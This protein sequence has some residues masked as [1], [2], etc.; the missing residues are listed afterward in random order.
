MVTGFYR[1]LL[2]AASGGRHFMLA[3][4]ASIASSSLSQWTRGKA[5][6]LISFLTLLYYVLTLL[7]VWKKALVFQQQSE[8]REGQ[9]PTQTFL[10]GSSRVPAPRTRSHVSFHAFFL[11][12]FRLSCRARAGDLRHM[13]PMDSFLVGYHF[14][15]SQNLI[16]IT[17]L[18]LTFPSFNMS[19]IEKLLFRKKKRYIA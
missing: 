14:N 1:M 11:S 12:H 19:N 16:K 5:S 4:R 8:P 18:S 2:A 17:W 7:I 3:S 13:P 9:P 6:L 15:Y 10:G